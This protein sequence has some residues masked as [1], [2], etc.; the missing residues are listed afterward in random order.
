MILEVIFLIQVIITILFCVIFSF[1]DLKK[2]FVPDKLNYILLTFGFLSN[3][4]LTIYTTN[5]KFILFSF[6]SW[7]VTFVVGLMLWRLNV[8]G[9]G[10][11]KLLASIASAIPS[12]L[13]ISFLNISPILSFYPFSFTVIVN[14]ILVSFPFLLLLLVYLII[15]FECFV[16]WA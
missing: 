3:L 4:I 5:I 14:S 2:G 8:W 16:F 6:I 15:F 10:D 9:G 13:N 7:S 11:V 1:Y 12:G